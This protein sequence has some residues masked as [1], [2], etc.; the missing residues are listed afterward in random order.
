M[1]DVGYMPLDLA[2][3]SPRFNS[4]KSPVAVLTKTN[5]R[6]F[7]SGVSMRGRFHFPCFIRVY[8]WLNPIFGSDLMPRGAAPQGMKMRRE[9]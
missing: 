8:P 6:F 5:L 2:N 4:K 9:R 1:L 7:F 3:V